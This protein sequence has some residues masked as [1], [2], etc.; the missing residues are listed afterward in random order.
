MKRVIQSL[1][2]SVL[3]CRWI[4]LL[5]VFLSVLLSSAATAQQAPLVVAITNT[6]A[7]FSIADDKGHLTGF[8]ADFVRAIC[9]KL[10][11]EC[12]FDAR[13]FPEILPR[14]AGGQA[15][16]GVGNYLRTPEREQQVRFTMPYWRSTSSF[17]GIPSH[18]LPPLDEL[19]LHHSLCLTEGSRQIDFIR[20]QPGR[21]IRIEVT[22]NNQAAFDGL[23]DGR[24]SLLLLPTLQALDF[25]RSPAGKPY[26]F[27]GK[28]LSEQGLGG[29]V[30]MVVRPDQPALLAQINAAIQALI[31]D[32][33][34]ERIARQYF[35]FKL[36]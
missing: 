6:V 23:R 4:A 9:D 31:D 10:K 3:K 11:R 33:T 27:L 2:D 8:N 19:G 25:L 1:R 18:R 17:I 20:K 14:V 26:A 5:K 36:L 32:G 7:S 29:D 28:P 34:H 15:D 13:P 30:H 21:P 22:G 24:C 12:R 35:P 16:L